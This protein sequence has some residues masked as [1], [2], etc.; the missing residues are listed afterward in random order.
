MSIVDTG[1][2]SYQKGDIV[3]LIFQT[4]SPTAD[5]IGDTINVEILDIFDNAISSVTAERIGNI[6]VSE[7]TI[8][9]DIESYYNISNISEINYDPTIMYIKDRWIISGINNDFEFTV[10]RRKESPIEQN[11]KIDINLNRIL[12]LDNSEITTSISFTTTLSPFYCSV[13][14]IVDIHPDYL[15]KV[16]IFSIARNIIDH[17]INLDLH[18]KP[19]VIVYESRFNNAAKNYISYEVAQSIL[20]SGDI[21]VVSE[22]KSIGTFSISKTYDFNR[23][24]LKEIEEHSSFYGNI[25]L[26]GGEDTPFKTRTFIKGIYDPNR[27]NIARAGLDTSDSYPFVNSSS[28]SSIIELNGR[29]IELRGVR[30]I[31]Y[32]SYSNNYNKNYQE[33]L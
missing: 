18:M 11:N 10:F 21:N 26:A 28:L 4:D 23:S 12:S 31:A 24:L 20:K 32:K 30:T 9:L 16:D 19:N 33:L 5:L 27:P 29:T 7:Y 2:G 17:S 13:A 15:S 25:V 22:S 1:T 3:E 8:P 14:D 6:Y